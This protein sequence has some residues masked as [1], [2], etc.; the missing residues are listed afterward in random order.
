VCAQSETDAARLS[1]LG[2][3]GVVV[4]GNLKFDLV[5][6]EAQAAA[7][8]AWRK[9]LGR[10]VLLLA[11]TREGEERLL[12]D[13]LPAQLGGVLVVFVP[14]HPQRFD[15]VARLLG[16]TT[17]GPRRRS[18]G[19]LPAAGARFYLGDSLGEMAFYYAAADVAIIGGSF[20]PLGG[21][22]LIEAC[23]AGTPVVLGPSMFN[24]AEATRLAL[25]AG[26][27][28]QCASTGEALRAALD[29]C[30]DRPR[31]DRMGE[32]GRRLCAAHRG[33]TGRHLEL[34]RRALRV[35]ARD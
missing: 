18:R 20:L 21:Q 8:R 4:T 16:E 32:A 35:R 34:C 9:A 2:A 24:F 15:E 17:A 27:A 29:L 3:N 25:E 33:A 23:A 10:P 13:A 14:R 11:S 22:N 12:L 30:A 19:E 1:A 7:G 5:P 6:D 26:A 28:L 31:R